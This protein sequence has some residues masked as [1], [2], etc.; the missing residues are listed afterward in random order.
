MIRV[1]EHICQLHT[2]AATTHN[3]DAFHRFVFLPANIHYVVDAV[4]TEDEICNII[5]FQVVIASRYDCLMATT[6]GTNVEWMA[7]DSN[8]FKFHPHD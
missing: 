4:A 5:D 7:S 2:D 6:D 8:I 1:V 3:E